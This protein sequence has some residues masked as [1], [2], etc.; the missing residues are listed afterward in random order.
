MSI[1]TKIHRLKTSH[2]ETKFEVPEAWT[3]KRHLGSGAYGTVYAFDLGGTRTA[4]KKV[5]DVLSDCVKAL[6]TLREIRLLA[7]LQHPNVLGIKEVFINGPRFSDVYLCLELMDCDLQTMVR[8]MG[9][10]LKDNH[11]RSIMHQITCGLLCLHTA[12]IIHRDLKPGNVLVTTDG[13]VKL[14]DF[15]LARAIEARRVNYD[16]LTEYVVT[17]FYRAPE[18]V[19]SA[20][21]YSFAVDVWS[22][23][24]ILG[25]MFLKRPLFQGRDCLDQIRSI[26]TELGGLKRNDD[27]QWLEQGSSA[28]K[29]IDS[30]PPFDSSHK[31]RFSLWQQLKNVEAD[32]EAR[33]LLA[34]ML[35][36]NPK[37]RITARDML[38]HDYLK[39][40][41]GRKYDDAEAKAL[42]ALPIDWAFDS[43]FCYDEAGEP[44]P[45]DEISFRRA[46]FDSRDIVDGLARRS[47]STNATLLKNDILST[48]GSLASGSPIAAIK[49]GKMQL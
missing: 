28:L 38:V 36:F 17:R 11:F 13:T 30:L 44:K 39:V 15:G 20:T 22:A 45:L 1:Q 19:L 2:G 37:K 24:C 43:E 41:R 31:A 3:P 48:R 16:G 27:L 49:R 40:C 21:E 8:K 29:F 23:G 25:E 35:Q 5:D 9:S 47:N 32:P 34:M 14:A 42:A 10:N 4:V 33:D 6:R 7:H 26:I 18:V 46:M 12:S